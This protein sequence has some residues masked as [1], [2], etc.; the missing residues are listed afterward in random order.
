MNYAEEALELPPK[1]VRHRNVELADSVCEISSVLPACR[2]ELA[3]A[4]AA[5]VSVIEHRVHVFTADDKLED[6]LRWR[7]YGQKM[8]KG[9][10]HPRSYFKCTTPGCAIQKHVE[11]SAE[12]ASLF[13]ARAWH[14]TA[15]YSWLG[16][17]RC[18]NRHSC[19]LDP[20]QS[21]KPP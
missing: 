2:R 4:S 3:P 7:K 6:G 17:F 19:F 1:R 8:V 21:V 20:F 13:M 10:L 12:E 15:L 5:V 9:A 14:G 16:T 18:E 11:Q